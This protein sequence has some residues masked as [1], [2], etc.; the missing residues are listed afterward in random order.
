MLNA[1]ICICWRNPAYSARLP[2]WSAFMPWCP[3]AHAWRTQTLNQSSSQNIESPL[4]TAV[5]NRAEQ[6]F[7]SLLLKAEVKPFWLET[8]CLSWIMS[9]T[10]QNPQNMQSL[11]RGH[12]IVAEHGFF[13]IPQIHLFV[14]WSGYIHRNLLPKSLRL[15]LQERLEATE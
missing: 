4:Q 12:W 10:K 6:D 5:H 13:E 9:S 3:T 11:P 14:L 15:M 7:F 8:S 2:V 1:T